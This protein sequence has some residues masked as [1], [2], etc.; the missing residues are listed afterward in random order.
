V[1]QCRVLQFQAFLG[2]FCTEKQLSADRFQEFYILTKI[3]I[4]ILPVFVYNVFI[5]V[6]GT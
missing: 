2:V 6:L 4:E 3:S 1:E 5:V